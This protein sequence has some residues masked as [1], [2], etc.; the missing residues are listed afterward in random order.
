[1]WKK[2]TLIMITHVARPTFASNSVLVVW[3]QCLVN[4][5][6]QVKYTLNIHVAHVNGHSKGICANTK[7]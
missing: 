3:N 1:M 7:S 5:M 6:Y 2:P 4:V